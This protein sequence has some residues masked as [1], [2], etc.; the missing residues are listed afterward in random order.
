MDNK[1]FY[2]P[3]DKDGERIGNTLCV[4]VRDGRIFIGEAVCSVE[5]QFCK[6]TG[7][8]FAS[9]RAEAAYE[10]WIS[11]RNKKGFFAKL[12]GG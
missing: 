3:K 2:Y 5:D 10:S 7:R 6:A 1:C 8:E 4:L 11:N 9:R 12:F